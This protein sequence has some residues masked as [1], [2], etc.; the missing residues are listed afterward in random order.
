MTTFMKTLAL[1]L[2][3]TAAACSPKPPESSQTIDGTTLERVA[4]ISKLLSK[5]APLPS[6]LLDAHFVEEQTGDG[7]LGPSDFKA[8]YA[9]TVAPADL[10]AWRAALSESKTWN[11]FANDEDIRRAAPKKAQ[12]WW[13]SVADLGTLEFYSPQSLT[14]RFNGWVGIAPDGRIFVYSFTM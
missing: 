2:L 1:L 6:S 14:G 8:F 9:L 7:R 11:R 5:T 4:V 12:P 10:P 13:V 3:C